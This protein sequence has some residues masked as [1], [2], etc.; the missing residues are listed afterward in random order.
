MTQTRR[1]V[2]VTGA[3]GYIGNAVAKAFNRAGWNTYGLIRR[4]EDASDLAKNEIHPIIGAPKDFMSSP[5]GDG[6]GRCVF[7]V[8][9]SNTE[10]WFNYEQHFQEIQSMLV[11]IGQCSQNQAG[12]R[13]LVLFSSG[14]KD[15]G[16]TGCHGDPDLAPHTESSPL[17]ALGLLLPRT[18]SCASLLESS[19]PDMP[20]D[21]T[22][23]RPTTVYGYGCSYYGPLFALAERSEKD[24]GGVLRILANPNSIMHGTHVDDC[25]EAYVALADPPHRDEIRGQA[26]N[27]SNARYET[28][29]DICEALA[30]S[31]GLSSVE[32]EPPKEL[33]HKVVPGMAE[34]VLQYSQWVSSEKLRTLTGWDEKRAYFADGIAEYR[35]SYEAAVASKHHGTMRITS[36]FP[37]SIDMSGRA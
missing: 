22:L 29:R 15:Y 4:V 34:A 18:R 16:T 37:D 10:D 13:P 23:L 7:D 1:K 3:N 33:L 28:V 17:N 20:F 12:I 32:Y 19:G 30:R 24:I 25:A 36:I 27:I 2:L 5:H 9:V 26:F 21:V 11:H 6:C 14:C 35:L 31:Y 8:V